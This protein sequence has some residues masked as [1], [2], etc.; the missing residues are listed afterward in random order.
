MKK[1]RAEKPSLYRAVKVSISMPQFLWEWIDQQGSPGEMR[2]RIVQRLLQQL[3]EKTAP[4]SSP[5][6]GRFPEKEVQSARLNET[7]GGR[8][9]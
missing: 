4:S 5:I 7:D 6:A 9:K 2:S 1:T 3:R 8:G